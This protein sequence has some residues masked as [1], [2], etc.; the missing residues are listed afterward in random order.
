MPPLPSDIIQNLQNSD[1]NSN[2]EKDTPIRSI[3]KKSDTEKRKKKDSHVNYAFEFD[4]IPQVT[5]KKKRPKKPKSA[6]V[7]DKRTGRSKSIMIDEKTDKN[8]N[9]IV[10]AEVH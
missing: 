10:I 6:T 1:Q 3:L 7:I 8:T 5:T 9:H 2:L 4:E